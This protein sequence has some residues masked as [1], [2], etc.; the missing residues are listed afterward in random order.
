MKST[1]V[2]NATVVVPGESS[3]PGTVVFAD[4]ITSILPADAKPPVGANVIDARGR[5][6]TPGLVDL[7]THGIGRHLYEN[8]PEDLV[9][10]LKLPTR[11][12]CTSLTPTLYSE[13]KPES[14]KHV[15]KLT[16]AMKD[17]HGVHIPG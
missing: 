12:G 10:G 17:V 13:M 2:V 4:R 6:L 8:S 11:F 5:T 1:C 9:A 15:E 16:K 14:L 7:H 3:G